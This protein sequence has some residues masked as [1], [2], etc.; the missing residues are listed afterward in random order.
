MVPLKNGKKLIIYYKMYICNKKGKA[1]NNRTLYETL[2]ENKK[3]PKNSKKIE[4][5]KK[6]EKTIR[7]IIA[8]N[9]SI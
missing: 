6:S 1:E 4:E 8:D 9:R 5:T 7:D 2:K 3:E